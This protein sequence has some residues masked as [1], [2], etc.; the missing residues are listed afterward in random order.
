[1]PAAQATAAR[2]FMRGILGFDSERLRDCSDPVP[3]VTWRAAR[4]HRDQ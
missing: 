4:N 1:L 2:V 3:I